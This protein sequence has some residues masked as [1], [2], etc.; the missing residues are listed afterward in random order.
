MTGEP[1]A[2][3]LRL[4]EQ[5]VATL[6]EAGR[7]TGHPAYIL[8][9]ERSWVDR[10][11]RPVLSLG[12]L[13]WRMDIAR[14]F[15]G[16]LPAFLT[17]LLPERDGALRRRIARAACIDEQDDM[18]LLL[19]VG[20]DMSGAIVCEPTEGV[21]PA[22]RVLEQSEAPTALPA[23]R[24]RWSLGGIQLKF[25]V[26][27]RER[28]VLPLH[29]RG[30]WILK[31]PDIRHPGLARAEY[32]AMEW[33]RAVGFEVPRV[34]VM[35][36]HEVD[37]LPPDACENLSEALLVQRFDR[38]EDLVQIHMEEMASV[39]RV[40]PEF[41]YPDP[42]SPHAY[43]LVVVGRLVKRFAGPDALR[44][45][46]ARVV[47]DV[48]AGNGDA[49]LKNWAFL[50]PDGRT[51]QLAPAYDILPTILYGYPPEMALPLTSEKAFRAFDI[52]RIRQW[53]LKLEVSPEEYVDVARE[54]VARA[55]ATFH[56][57]MARCGISGEAVQ[58]LRKHWESLPIVRLQE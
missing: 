58:V 53:A 6:V 50:F 39:L 4:H 37:G 16:R 8:Q 55:A 7:G 46:L 45:L 29:G 11:E 17:N 3:G 14:R 5:P 38:R 57:V 56:E 15:P 40:H 35:D 30:S 32:A 19:Y 42:P 36:P 44:T 20:R 9:F 48:M 31:I 52:S 34:E 43:N 10:V 51:P 25:S 12:A 13:D 49:H 21:T 26:E 54:T 22:R 47:F 41:K 1:R 23:D 28:V 2:V 24:L 27:R 18:A 33:A